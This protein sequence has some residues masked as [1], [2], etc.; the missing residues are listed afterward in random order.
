MSSEHHDFLSYSPSLPLAAV[1]LSLY[2]VMT[3]LHIFRTLKTSTWDN[4]PFV[5]GGIAQTTGYALRTALT[6]SP[7]S[8]ALYNGMSILLLL[9]PSLLM[10]TI[11][12]T[13]TAYIASL[14]AGRFT[15]VPLRFQRFIYLSFTVLCLL[16]QAFGLAF[17][18]TDNAIRSIR[19][20]TQVIIASLIMQMFFWL[21]V[22]ADGLVVQF[23]LSRHGTAAAAQVFPRWKRWNSLF[24]LGIM[25]ICGRNLM[26]L[27]RYG[28]GPDGFLSLNEWTS[29]AFDG[30]QMVL[31]M[32]VWAMWYV[33]GRVRRAAES[34]LVV[35]DS[36]EL[37][38]ADSRGPL[39][40]S[41]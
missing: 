14:D 6:Q 40:E 38:R 32:G 5:L 28:M 31:V 37:S 41:P 34:K 35:S 39:Y 19:A 17:S 20:A 3:T 13:Q 23:R 16:V 12:L 24:G 1:A 10:V 27:T 15:L 11:V 36:N 8:S 26:V 29:Y 18:E 7:A 33:P 9:G 30:Y 25:I 21:F 22:F 2:T 4:I